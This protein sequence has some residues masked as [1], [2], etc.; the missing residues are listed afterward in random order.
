MAMRIWQ[1]GEG[2]DFIHLISS[3]MAIDELERIRIFMDRIGAETSAGL[4][5][6]LQI[7]VT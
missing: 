4:L 3:A 1:M 5:W 7:R 2:C 6:H